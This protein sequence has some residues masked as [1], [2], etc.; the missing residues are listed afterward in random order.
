MSAVDVALLRT[1]GRVNHTAPGVAATAISG[2]VRAL[3]MELACL[4]I[5][6]GVNDD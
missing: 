5:D 6:K 4:V 1:R 2:L 3:H